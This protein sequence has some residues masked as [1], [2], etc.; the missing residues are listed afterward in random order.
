NKKSL[1][2]GDN[3]SIPRGKAQPA[4]QQVY[5]NTSTTPSAP[6]P[7]LNAQQDTVTEYKVGKSETLYAISKCFDINIETTKKVNNLTSDNLREGQ[8]LKNPANIN[9]EE[10]T[11]V[12]LEDIPLVI[13]DENQPLDLSDFEANRYGI[14]E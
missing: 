5:S 11:V 4:A 10:H 6:L 9:P 8:I 7:T 2:I 13:I 12:P 14:R 1:R 3:D